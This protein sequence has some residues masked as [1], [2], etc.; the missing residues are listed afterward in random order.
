MKTDMKVK[1]VTVELVDGNKME[2]TGEMALFLQD[3]MTEIEKI[4]HGDDQDK[5]CGVVQCS[6][7]FL[8]SVTNAA[9]ATLSERA[10]GLD[11]AVLVKHLEDKHPELAVLEHILG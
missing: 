2:F 6:P 11:S 1:K 7:M 4:L 10:P 9:L 5:V 3:K 8:A